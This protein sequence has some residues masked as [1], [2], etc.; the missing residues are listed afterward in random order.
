V[1]LE[2]DVR[3]TSTRISSALLVCR[4]GSKLVRLGD[5]NERIT[6]AVAPANRRLVRPLTCVPIARLVPSRGCFDLDTT[7]KVVGGTT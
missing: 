2:R 1:D 3:I 5:A 7:R 6:P 4:H